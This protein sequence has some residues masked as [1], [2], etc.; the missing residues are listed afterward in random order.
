MHRE[1]IITLVSIVMTIIVM[2]LVMD[3][4]IIGKQLIAQT[5]VNMMLIAGK[6]IEKSVG[7]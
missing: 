5:R 3:Y 6:I 4:T 2:F 1:L 7:S